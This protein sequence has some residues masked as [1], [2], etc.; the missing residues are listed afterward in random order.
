MSPG[1]PRRLQEAALAVRPALDERCP[2]EMVVASARSRWRWTASRR[3]G[4]SHGC[5]AAS[6]ICACARGRRRRLLARRVRAPRVGTRIDKKSHFTARKSRRR[7]KTPTSCAKT[8]G[9][10]HQTPQPIRTH[11]KQAADGRL[12]RAGRREDEEEAEQ[13]ANRVEGNKDGGEAEKEPG[14]GAGKDHREGAAGV[15]ARAVPRAPPTAAVGDAD[16]LRLPARRPRQPGGRPA[17]RHRRDGVRRVPRA[18]GAGAHGVRGAP[19][20]LEP[21][22]A[23]LPA[24]GDDLERRAGHLV[25]RGAH[26]GGGA[27]LRV[28]RAARLGLHL[29]ALP[30]VA[31][32]RHRRG[33]ARRGGRAR[34]GRRSRRWASCSPRPSRR[35]P[36]RRGCSGRSARSTTRW[37]RSR[38]SRSSRSRPSSSLFGERAF[39]R[40]FGSAEEAHRI[41]TELSHRGER[42][43]PLRAHAEAARAH[44]ARRVGVRPHVR[45]AAGDGAATATATSTSTTTSAF[46][47]TTT[48]LTSSTIPHLQGYL[49]FCVNHSYVIA[50]LS[51]DSEVGGTILAF[52]L[53]ADSPASTACAAR[54]RRT[55]SPAASSARSSSSPRTTRRRPTT[56]VRRGSTRTA[57]R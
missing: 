14:G 9:A 47:T 7:L 46:T 26:L 57:R 45:L 49:A 10:A 18:D 8:P 34:C 36:A 40:F 38:C 55:T 23:R 17:R 48:T 1:S 54:A 51:Y 12:R 16:D 30:A 56:S 3:R 25:G 43:T 19:R 52:L 31:L 41:E 4:R 22:A 15:R 5:S 42:L 24:E 11:A 32:L 33:A 6:L 2:L 20:Q 50:L 35:C 27:P 13:Q 44:A 39:T 29:P 28:G 53:P 37:R 21:P